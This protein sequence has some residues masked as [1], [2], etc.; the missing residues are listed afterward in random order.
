MRRPAL[1]LLFLCALTFFVGLGL[2]AITDADEAFYAESAREM[3]DRGDWL[4]PY[5]NDE[6]RWQKPILYYWLTA[7]TYLIAGIGEWSARAWSALAGLG[8][9]FVT[10]GAGARLTGRADA[11]WLAGA[12]AA[13]CFGY[14]AVARMALPDLPLAFFVTLAI[15]SAFDDR[16]M[17]AG[18][19]AGL[20]FLTKGPLALILPALVFLPVWWRERRRRRVSARSLALGAVVCAAV[21]LPW[22]VAM[23]AEHGTAYLQSFFVGDNLE[24]FATD[25]FNSPRSPLF[26]VPVVAGG[27]LPWTPYLAVCLWRGGRDLYARGLALTDADWRLAIWAAA[28]LVFFSVSIGKQPRYILPILPPIAVLLARALLR[29]L[30]AATRGDRGAQR[31]LRLATRATAVL[32]AVVA[33]L[34]VRARELFVPAIPAMTWIAAGA[35]IACAAALATLAHGRRLERLP[36]VLPVCAAVTFTA[37]QFGALSGRRP[38]PVEEMAA[39][40]RTHRGGGEAIGAYHEFVR[41]L[42]FYTG[43]PQQDLFTDERAVTFMRSPGRVLMVVRDTDLPRLETASGVT[44]TRLGAVRYFNTAN[45][46][47]RVLLVP[48]P[49]RD[50]ERVLLVTNRATG[51]S[52]PD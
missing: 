48:D 8:L 49:G 45:V 6:P 1:V 42:V 52:S 33:L 37:V 4:T 50:V 29:R 22:Y 7:V 27:L 46:K 51:K 20:G 41:N 38:E 28:P 23:T 9:V 14:F 40:V 32:L 35:L 13:T 25:R 11:G 26:Y 15:A 24:R 47:L 43:A 3:V 10:W 34:L 30:E 12:I 18:L 36:I 39:L 16:W 5:Y 19:A 31:D 44:M 21:G 2:P 17:L